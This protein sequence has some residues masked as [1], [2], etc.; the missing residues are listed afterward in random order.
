MEA[1]SEFVELEG[2]YFV[3]S[4]ALHV[5]KSGGSLFRSFLAKKFDSMGFAFFIASPN[6]WL[7][8]ATKIIEE[9]HYEYIMTYDNDLIVISVNTFNILNELRSSVKLKVIK[10]T[11]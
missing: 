2:K 1:R 4:K 9:E 6:V 8:P 11:S 3:L 7:R 10:I 5:L